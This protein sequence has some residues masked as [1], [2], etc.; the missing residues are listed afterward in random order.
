MWHRPVQALCVLPQSLWVHR[1]TLHA[2]LEGLVSLVPYTPLPP[3]LSAPSSMGFPETWAEGFDGDIPFRAECSWSLVLPIM[4]GCGSLYLF[5][6]AATGSFSDDGWSMRTAACHEGSFYYC[7]VALPQGR[8]TRAVSGMGSIRCS[9][10]SVK[11]DALQLFSVCRHHCLN[12]YFRQDPIV[13]QRVC[14]WIGVYASP[15]GA[16][17]GPPGTKDTSK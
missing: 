16:W 11:A 6:S 3:T 14:G 5:P 15:S 12:I 10:P 8:V 9:G 7:Y 2:N 4:S 1:R 17:P 13:D